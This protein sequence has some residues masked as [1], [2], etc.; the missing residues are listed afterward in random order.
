MEILTKWLLKL[1]KPVK[2]PNYLAGP[3]VYDGADIDST[4][5]QG[6]VENRQSRRKH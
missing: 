6:F 3:R 5:T 1:F 4:A 2:V